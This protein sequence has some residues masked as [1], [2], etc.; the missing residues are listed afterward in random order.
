MEKTVYFIE[1]KITRKW[2]TPL[3]GTKGYYTNNPHKAL[4]FDTREEAE[5]YGL[6]DNQIITQHLFVEETDE[7]I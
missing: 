7:F 2:I 6:E 4:L 3:F 1:N 5:R